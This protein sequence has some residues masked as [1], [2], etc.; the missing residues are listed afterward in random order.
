[1]RKSVILLAVLAMVV[2]LS[3]PGG[4]LA[5]QE[6]PQ[7]STGLLRT[8]GDFPRLDTAALPHSLQADPPSFVDLS[9][10][11]PPLV[12]KGYRTV[13]LAGLWGT[14]ARPSWSSKSAAG[15]HRWPLTNLAPPTSTIS[16]TQLTVALMLA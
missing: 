13:V 10:D 16:A 5:D 7:F 1:M 3:L 8:K 14:M 11:L 15:A 4:T 6:L 12:I 9:A 2:L